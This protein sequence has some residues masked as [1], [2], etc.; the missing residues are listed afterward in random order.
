MN[1]S[2]NIFK[3]K[4]SGLLHRYHV[5]LFVLVVIGSLAVVVLILNNI[6][7][8]SESTTPT[9]QG[10][11]TTTFDQTTIDR[12]KQLRGRDQPPVP[13]DLTKGR[14]NPFVE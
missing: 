9:L 14:T 1:I 13:L 8:K 11:A 4:L 2:L 3:K 12:L 7:A 10:A 6:I 5:I